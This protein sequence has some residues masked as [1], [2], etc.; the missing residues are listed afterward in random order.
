MGLFL[1]T[2]ALLLAGIV[3]FTTLWRD[4]PAASSACF[5]AAS[6]ASVC[7]SIPPWTILP[8][9]RSMPG[10]PETKTKPFARTTGESGTPV[11]R[12]VSEMTGTSM[13][14]FMARS[15][16]GPGSLPCPLPPGPAPQ[17]WPATIAQCES[18][19]AATR[20]NGAL[21]DWL[22]PLLVPLA[23]ALAGALLV[24]AILLAL[25]PRGGGSE[26]MLILADRMESLSDR[27]GGPGAGGEHKQRR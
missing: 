7:A 3:R 20:G 5:T 1:A 15:L 25:R 2:Q 16:A 21:P 11:F 6:D 22:L 13:I 24:G 17:G 8:V 18:G 19:G 27:L 23:A 26:G 12:M 10:R 9:A 4:H 14:S